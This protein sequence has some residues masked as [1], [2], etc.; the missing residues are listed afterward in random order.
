VWQPQ[1]TSVRVL[2]RTRCVVVC[3]SAPSR[4]P[5]SRL[6]PRMAAWLYPSKSAE[7]DK[8]NK[9]DAFCLCC[10]VLVAVDDSAGQ[11]IAAFLLSL[12]L[13]SS[14]RGPDRHCTSRP[15]FARWLL[16]VCSHAL[17]ARCSTPLLPALGNC[18][19]AARYRATCPSPRH[20]HDRCVL[21][22]FPCLS[23][24]MRLVAP[25]PHRI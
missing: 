5:P 19:H 17:L 13:P 2:F 23:L 24:F 20:V 11:V 8:Q 15:I 7:P 3:I 16:A 9:N 18:A 1:A 25:N 14:P 6:P 21:A 10:L 12:A 22:G 4:D